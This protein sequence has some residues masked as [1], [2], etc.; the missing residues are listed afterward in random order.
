MSH[1]LVIF[2]VVQILNFL[3]SCGEEKAGADYAGIMSNISRGGETTDPS[4]S[5]VR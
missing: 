4:L 3:D 2:I 5:A 1:K